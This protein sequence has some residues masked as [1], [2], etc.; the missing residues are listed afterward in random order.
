MSVL[1]VGP[2]RQQDEWGY[3]S[4]AFANL[5]AAQKEQLPDLVMR[6]VWFNNQQKL[7]DIG[8]LEEYEFKKVDSPDVII[9]HGLPNYLNYNGNFKKNI[10]VT[11]V[12]C[13]VDNTDWVT[14]LNLFDT[15]VVF[16]EHEAQLLKDSGVT[17]EV[18]HFDFAPLYFSNEVEDLNLKFNRFKFYTIGSLDIKSGLREVV[19]SYLSA[20]TILDNVML[21]VCSSDAQKLEEEIKVIKSGLGKFFD[22]Q[23]YPHIAI[24]NNTNLPILNYVH[25][26]CDCYIDASYNSRT[27]QNMLKAIAYNSLPMMTDVCGIIKDYPFTIKTH[28]DI[29]IY[30][31]RPIRELYSGEFSWEMPSMNSIRANMRA[32]YNADEEVL[33]KASQQVMKLKSSLFK[34]PNKRIVD[35]LCT[36]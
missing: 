34:I 16:S 26:Y 36:Q 18:F 5:L 12:D 7:T 24:I 21:V 17:T 13:R 1:Y 31:Q 22:E 23:H 29:S 3:T 2:Y 19:A 9:Q 6:P 4:R 33:E 15:V 10:A 25:D 8:Q 27:N 30:P 14:H 11:S 20:F 35:L 32:I 28:N